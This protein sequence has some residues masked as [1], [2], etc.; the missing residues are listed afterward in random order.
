MTASGVVRGLKGSVS[1]VP[2]YLKKY[3]TRLIV[4][5]MR[6]RRMITRRVAIFNGLHTAWRDTFA[7]LDPFL[8]VPAGTVTLKTSSARDTDSYSMFH[9]IDESSGRSMEAILKDENIKRRLYHG[10]T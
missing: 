1:L 5:W 4:V 10:S 7:E 6:Y 8:H 9:S 2:V 3:L